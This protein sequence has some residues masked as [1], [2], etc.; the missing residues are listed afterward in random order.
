MK[1]AILIASLVFMFALI[2]VNLSIAADIGLKGIGGRAGFVMPDQGDNTFG[3]GVVFDLGTIISQLALEA[4]ADYFG[5]SYDLLGAKLSSNIINFNGMVKYHFP[6]GGNFSPFAGG[7]F[8][9]QY[10]RVKSEYQAA[11]LWGVPVGE[12]SSSESE[13]DTDL[14]IGGGVDFPIGTGMKFTAEARY[15]LDDETIWLT[16]GIILKLK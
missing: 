12:T 6:V 3:L 11:S 1:R 10:A 4:S 15:F 7:G 13:T 8:T 5:Y 14:H 9:F 16:G 2:S